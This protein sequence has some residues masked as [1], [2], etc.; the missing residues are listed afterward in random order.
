MAT[1]Q[2]VAKSAGVSPSTVSRVINENGYVAQIVR[3][4]VL[5]AIQE[6]N[7]IPN[8]AAR[9][10]RLRE[11]RQI[12]CITPSINNWFYTEILEGIEERAL[13]NGYTFSLYNINYEKREYLKVVL[14]GLYDGL[15]VLAPYE[16]RKIMSLEEISNRLPVSLYWDR[17]EQT[18]ISH[19]YVNLRK[20]MKQ[21]VSH[22]ID[23]GHQEIIFL[24]YEF[25]SPLENPRYQGYMDAMEEYGLPVSPYYLSFIE[26]YSDTLTTGYRK[27]KEFIRQDHSFTSI[28]ACNDLLAVGAM[29]ALIESG[30]K[31]PHDISVVG[32]DDI[33][34]ASIVS[35]PLTT[36][37]IPKRK[38]GNMLASQLLSQ[39]NGDKE[40]EHSLSYDANLIIRESVKSI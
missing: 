22:L 26:E 34:L 3:E 36:M 2:D 5:K 24:G 14:E 19:V 9:S 15:I 13:E 8:R 40:L 21:A 37:C 18:S 1:R 7:Y 31:V 6:L 30:K 35:P 29:R 38:I 28:V 10:L 12:A 23:Q 33:E 25:Q 27:V 4:R 20:A 11:C 16:L 17:E 32:I 39:I